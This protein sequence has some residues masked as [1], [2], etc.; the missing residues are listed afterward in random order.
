MASGRPRRAA[1]AKV[2]AAQE[3]RAKNR[4]RQEARKASGIKKPPK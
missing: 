2:A 3:K 4:E 1:T